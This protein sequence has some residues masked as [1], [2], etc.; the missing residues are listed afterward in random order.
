MSSNSTKKR[1]TNFLIKLIKLLNLNLFQCGQCSKKVEG[2]SNSLMWEAMIFCNVGCLCNYAL[3]VIT[4][5][6][7]IPD[8]SEYRTVWLSGIQMVKSRDLADYSNT[9]QWT[10]WTISRV[11][12]SSVFRPPFEYRT[13]WQPDT[14][15]PFEYQTSAVFRWLLYDITW[16]WGIVDR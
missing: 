9:G 6:I 10:F 7:W 8:S 1:E 13:V 3:Y 11:F 5:T 4:V 2:F 14:N 16:H 12:F 15:L